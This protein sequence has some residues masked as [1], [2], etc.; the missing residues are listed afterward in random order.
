MPISRQLRDF[1]ILVCGIVLGILGNLLAEFFIAYL[2]PS[3]FIPQNKAIESIKLL[4]LAI[5]VD[6]IF[7]A[8]IVRQK[9]S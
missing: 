1:A 9:A 5:V 3:G 2:Y 6:V 7:L 4:V 8:I